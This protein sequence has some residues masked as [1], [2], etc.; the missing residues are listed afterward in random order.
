MRSKD[1]KGWDCLFLAFPLQFLLEREDS[2]WQEGNR[3]VVG[4]QEVRDG[5]KKA[6]SKGLGRIEK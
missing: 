6:K 4:G 2:Y 3:M 5:K 1:K